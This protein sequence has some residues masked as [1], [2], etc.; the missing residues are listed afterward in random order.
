MG[1]RRARPIKNE[2]ILEAVISKP[3]SCTRSETSQRAGMKK[4]GKEKDATNN[5]HPSHELRPYVSGRKGDERFPAPVVLGDGL[6]SNGWV[7][8]GAR[9]EEEEAGEL[10][11]SACV[12]V[13]M[14]RAKTGGDQP[15]RPYERVRLKSLRYKRY[16][17]E[18]EGKEAVS[19]SFLPL[20]VGSL[21]CGTHN[22][23]S[24]PQITPTMRWQS[25]WKPTTSSLND[26]ITSL[27]EG[28]EGRG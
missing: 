13:L 6:S 19:S 14:N 5:Q 7:P 21:V 8:K 16:L 27:G 15:A 26:A 4:R 1:A 24:P 10:D 17:D 18:C 9:F 28:Q 2:A 25:S 23:T 22:S 20:S 3:Q 12:R 11:A